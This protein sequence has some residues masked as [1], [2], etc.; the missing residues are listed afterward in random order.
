MADRKLNLGDAKVLPN[1]A[2]TPCRTCPRQPESCGKQR[3]VESSGGSK[4]MCMDGRGF[5]EPVNEPL[6]EGFASTALENLSIQSGRDSEPNARRAVVAYLNILS[7]GAVVRLSSLHSH[8]VL[9][10][11]VRPNLSAGGANG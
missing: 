3:M 6:L 11:Q 7:E 4:V 5:V 9:I 1:V 2:M 10:K 8:A